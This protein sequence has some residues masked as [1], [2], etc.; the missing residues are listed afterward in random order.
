MAKSISAED[1]RLRNS[2]EA[3]RRLLLDERFADRL[4]RSLSYWALAADRRLPLALLDHSLRDILQMPFERMAATPGI[5]RKKL[6]S[7]IMLLQRATED[8]PL[9]DVGL[10]IS[11]SLAGVAETPP[12]EAA[13]APAAVIGGAFPATHSAEFDPSTVS[14]TMWGQWCET[15]RRHDLKR[16]RLGRLAPSLLDLPTVIWNTPLSDYLSQSLSEIRQRRTHG[17]KRI[18]VVLEL[19]YSIHRL[20]AAVGT[21]QRLSVRLM[22]R[23]ISPVEDWLAELASRDAL[24]DELEVRQAL[25]L[26]LLNQVAIDGGPI[27]QK[28]AEGRLG[29]EGPPQSVRHQARRLGVTRARVYQL[30][31]SCGKIMEVRWPEGGIA[32]S[33]YADKF[34]GAGVDSR[35]A[36]LFCATR[37]LFYPTRPANWDTVVDARDGDLRVDE[38]HDLGDDHGE[39]HVSGAETA[40]ATGT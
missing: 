3:V 1:Y 39:L 40:D 18:R 16:E 28:L 24:P 15:I 12:A 14:E 6:G 32:L 17:Q 7:L 21:S 8:N 25:V 5:G 35:A 34:R 38:A 37:D 23:F 27:V 2:F 22:P 26:P 33:Y 36:Q 13:V 4:D 19:F 29:I 10:G 11:A 20:L 9:A 31:E 30:L